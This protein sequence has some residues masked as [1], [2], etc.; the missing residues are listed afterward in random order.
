MC[1]F[2]GGR[3][4]CVLLLMELAGAAYK[5]VSEVMRVTKGA[6]VLIVAD[7]ATGEDIVKATADACAIL[8]AKAAVMW[9]QTRAA[10]S[11]YYV[12]K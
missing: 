10:L 12:L 7:T 2:I 6:N 1:N 3:L 5:L 8:G 4:T 11:L 9:F